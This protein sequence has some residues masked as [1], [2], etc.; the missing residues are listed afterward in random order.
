MKKEE[1]KVIAIGVVMILIAAYAAIGAAAAT[2]TITDATS[3]EPAV[4]WALHEDSVFQSMCE[5]TVSH[6]DVV[7][8][9][10]A[11]TRYQISVVSE[12]WTGTIYVSSEQ[13][14]VL[15]E[16]DKI[17]IVQNQY[18]AWNYVNVPKT[19]T[20]ISDF[21]KDGKHTYAVVETEGKVPVK[22]KVDYEYVHDIKLGTDVVLTVDKN[23]E[24]RIEGYSYDGAVAGTVVMVIFGVI[25]LGFFILLIIALA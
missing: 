5:A 18:E 22:I 25:I 8:S 3:A 9:K 6:M 1:L 20:Y 13:Y 7:H 4:K 11:G 23:G 15:H 21:V 2:T 19:E 17:A 14:A 12:N 16:G 24:P 10:S